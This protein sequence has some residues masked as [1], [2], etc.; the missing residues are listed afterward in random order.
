MEGLMSGAAGSRGAL[1]LCW[2]LLF[3]LVP[4][5]DG[6]AAPIT[7]EYWNVK[8]GLQ[9]PVEVSH[10]KFLG[11][12]VPIFGPSYVYDLCLGGE[13][14]PMYFEHPSG[15]TGA[16]FDAQKH[17]G[18]DIFG[19]FDVDCG[20]HPFEDGTYIA[21]MIRDGKFQTTIPSDPD[22]VDVTIR[23][24]TPATGAATHG[25][26]YAHVN[27]SAAVDSAGFLQVF[28][29]GDDLGPISGN[30]LHL[31]VQKYGS[32]ATWEDP[33]QFFERGT[34][35][36]DKCPVPEPGTVALLGSGLIVAGMLRRRRA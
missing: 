4:T 34:K 33:E 5:L 6:S 20:Y 13:C 36:C 35:T 29:A 17:P 23:F 26:Y 22:A 30:H 31:G 19:W 7:V 24:D 15:L 3:G 11:F 32:P 28:H 1:S 8:A 25:D 14:T 10:P 2:V 21:Q 27:A 16:R 12:F 18:W 9:K